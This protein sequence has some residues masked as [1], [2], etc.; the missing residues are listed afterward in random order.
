MLNSTPIP[1][2]EPIL[3]A[4]VLIVDDTPSNL[5]ALQAVLTEYKILSASSGQE[6]LN[7]LQKNE[8]NVILLDI[9]MPGMD[10]FETAKR[11]KQMPNYKNAP[12]LFITAVF[13][14]DPYVK[15][16]YEAGGIDYFTK[17]FDP[18]VLKMKVGIY[19]A[20]HRKDNLLQEREKRLKQSEE[21][22]RAGHKLS[23]VLESLPV[24]VII[25]DVSGGILQTNDIVLKIW[26]SI[27]PLKTESY[28]EF[29][30][31]WSSAGQPVKAAF[32][33]ALSTGRSSHNEIMTIECFDGTSK[34]ILSSASPLRALDNQIVGAVAVIQD[35]TEQKK[36]EAH[37]EESIMKLVS[38]GV[39]FEQRAPLLSP[40][41]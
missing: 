8:V 2:H 22:L 33:A 12:I 14:E 17:P 20:F 37:M 3:K 27:E 15:R 9:Q 26:K 40:P 10:G 18:D 11:I 1:L 32:S 29:I 41:I 7:L 38:I 31:W 5:I 19:A 34:T 23:A 21:I 16:G 36:I 13:K 30:Q 24:G 39:E 4:T 35:I 6:A 28:G 25:S